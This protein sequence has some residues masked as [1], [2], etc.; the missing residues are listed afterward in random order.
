MPDAFIIAAARTPIGAFRGA[1]KSMSATDLGAVAVADVLEKSGVDAS[2]VDEVIMGNVIGAGVGQAPARQA[3]LKGG[4]PTS[5]P[6]LTVN[7]VC[8]SGLKSVMLASQTVRLGDAK[9]IIAGGMESMTNAPHII[10]GAREGFRLGDG[11]H[12]WTRWS[13]D[14]LTCAFENVP[15]GVARRTHCS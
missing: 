11:K 8:G 2:A 15:H 6:A 12:L 4:L 7:K 3:A 9:A 5:V 14:G 13:A 10:P 1:F